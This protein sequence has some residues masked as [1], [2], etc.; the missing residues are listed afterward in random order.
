VIYLFLFLFF[1][2]A[3]QDELHW[4]MSHHN[5]SIS[6]FGGNGSHAR[7]GSRTSI[8]SPRTPASSFDPLSAA[9]SSVQAKYAL[10][11]PHS[12]KA[13]NEACQDFPGGNTRTV[14]HSS[15]FPITFGSYFRDISPFNLHSKAIPDGK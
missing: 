3:Q 14:L 4:I 5:I 6:T 7:Q 1:I 9:L 12:L 11:N 8:K 13:H 10:S 2:I 15:P